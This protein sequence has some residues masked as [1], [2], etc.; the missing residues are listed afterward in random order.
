MRMDYESEHDARVQYAHEQAIITEMLGIVYMFTHR[1]RVARAWV[2][3]IKHE[4]ADAQEMVTYA[5]ARY[6]EDI[7]RD[8]RNGISRGR[9]EELAVEMA[10]LDREMIAAEARGETRWQAANDF[11]TRSRN[12]RARARALCDI[13]GETRA[14]CERLRD[15]YDA[16]HRSG[17]PVQGYVVMSG[18]ETRQRDRAIAHATCQTCGNLL[19]ECM[20]RGM[21]ARARCAWAGTAGT[22]FG[23]DAVECLPA[24]DG[25]RMQRDA[26]AKDDASRA[27]HGARRERG[28][29]V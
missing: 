5:L 23:N 9:A 7:E 18:E 22:A 11:V 1:A 27:K 24:N 29:H 20:A 10:F 12:A 3:A 25:Q 16:R 17:E 21:P 4:I 14:E 19:S 13:C 26:R 2:E 6:A 8:V 28:A 15:A